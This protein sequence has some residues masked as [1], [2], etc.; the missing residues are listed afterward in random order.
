MRWQLSGRSRRI[1]FTLI[2]LLVVIAIIAI[3][4]A[5]LVPAVQ[6]VREAA[7]RSQSMNNLKQLA[8]A[9]HSYHD[10]KKRLPDNGT[11]SY[12]CWDWGP[13]WGDAPPRPQIALG[14]SWAY[15]I[16]PYI[17][18][19][20]LYNNW[21]F[22]TPIQTLMDPQRGGT[23]LAATPYTPGMTYLQFANTGPVTDYAPNAMVIGSGMNTL[24]SGTSYGVGAWSGA[25]A[26]WSS[27]RRKLSQITDGTSNTILLGVNAMATPVYSKRGQGKFTIPEGYVGAGTQRDA[28][29][30]PIAG[31]GIWEGEMLLRANCPDTVNWYA[32]DN[33]GT[34]LYKDYIPGNTYKVE[35]NWSMW[36]Q[37]TWVIVRDAPDVDAWNRFGSPYSG[38]CQFAMADG[39]VRTFNYNIAKEA[40][41]PLLTPNGGEVATLD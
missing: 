30:P 2:E 3:L 24:K 32:G 10:A 41:I 21:N 5:L 9:M 26:S 38:G 19:S 14:C 36:Y 31:A 29:D 23:G 8:L 4:I 17:E 6:K 34:T 28:D 16:L 27:F 7:A 20:N 25:A 1:G 12:T 37:Y 18:Q 33:P 40:Y 13:P 35:Y 15:Q 22:N 39:S 11:S